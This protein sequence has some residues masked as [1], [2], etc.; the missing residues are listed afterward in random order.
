MI[1]H[2]DARVQRVGTYVRNTVLHIG[3]RLKNINAFAD[4]SLGKSST[5]KNLI[6]IFKKNLQPAIL[7]RYSRV[8]GGTN[9][10]SCT[11]PKTFSALVNITSFAYFEFTRPNY[12]NVVGRF[13]F[14][15]RPRPW[16]LYNITYNINIMHILRPPHWCA[17]PDRVMIYTEELQTIDIYCVCVLNTTFP[18]LWLEKRVIS[19][20][21]LGTRSPITVRYWS[22]HTRCR[23]HIDTAE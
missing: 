21:S 14:I 19:C 6:K 18:H 3:A 4:I 10:E 13:S 1:N 8:H 20:A 17:S 9:I 22:V 5:V 23:S 15:F 7:L 16:F 12:N 11:R 2:Y